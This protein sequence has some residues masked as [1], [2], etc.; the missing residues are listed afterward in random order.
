M[1]SKTV[2]ITGCSSGIGRASAK[3][4]HDAGWT[5]YATARDHADIDGLADQGMETLALD[6]TVEDDIER[7]VDA[8]VTADERIDCVVNN[9]GYGET[10]AVEETTEEELHAQFAVNTYG[11]QQLMRE[12]LPHMRDQGSGTIVNVSSVGGRLAQ[13]GLGAYCASK[14]ALE[15]LSDAA[16]VE[17][18]RF[19]VDVVLI[20]PGPVDTAFEDKAGERL[21]RRGGTDGPYDDLYERLTEFNEGISTRGGRGILPTILGQMTVTPERVARTI[22]EAAQDPDP[23]ARYSVSIPHRLMAMGAYVPSTIRDEVFLQALD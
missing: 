14:F 19:G 21:A 5:V 4:F 3:Q 2:L 10:A 16:R 22:L 17:V 13:P 7:A 1:Q 23:K 18:D 8:V 20:E 9:A 11:P 15:A 6:V 12:A